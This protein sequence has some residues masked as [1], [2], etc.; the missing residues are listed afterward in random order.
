MHRVMDKPF[1]PAEAMEAAEELNK[2]IKKRNLRNLNTSHSFS[3]S[4]PDDVR[5][6]FADS[7]CAVK[8]SKDPFSDLRESIIEMI[9]DVGVRD[10][11]EMEELVY[12]FVVLNS[13]E[14][15]G[16][17]GDAFLSLWQVEETT[18]PINCP[19]H[20][21]CDSTYP[22]NYPSAVDVLLLLFTIA[23]YLVTLIFT[24]VEI[25]GGREHI[26]FS[27][28]RKYW[29]PSGPVALP[30]IL[31]ALA[32]GHRINTIFPLSRLGPA[33]L[34]LVHISAIAFENEAEE[35]VKYALFE[36]STVSGI[37]H[38]SLYLDSII[39]PYYTGL[40]ALV[41]STFSGECIS[42]VCRKEILVVGGRLV[43]YRG[44]SATTFSVV[45][46]LCLRI[47]CKLSM[48]GKGRSVLIKS[49][50]EIMCWIL[51]AMDCV[52]LMINSPQGGSLEKGAAFGGV[53]V[54]IC[55]HVLRKVGTQLTKRGLSIKE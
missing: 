41:T 14:I 40:D 12:C 9:N 45:G 4:L 29:L 55:L 52:H 26:R 43:V 5:G 36:V 39:L 33:L 48:E 27:R 25:S 17:I 32:K 20:Y 16:F 42:C 2:K 50:L 1:P 18:D 35:N 7:I 28:M 8:Y 21:F 19:Y 30:F 44:W 6:V 51:I 54:L 11:D 10:W 49:M 3:A 13:S 53:F 47:V 23:S 38:A 22:G 31:L 46:T 24:V 34:Q 37:L 15:H